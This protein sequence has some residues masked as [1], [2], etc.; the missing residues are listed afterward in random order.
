MAKFD[1]KIAKK[2]AKIANIQSLVT[3]MIC[4][5]TQL[6]WMATDTYNRHMSI[7]ISRFQDI[8]ELLRYEINQKTARKNDFGPQG[9]RKLGIFRKIK[10]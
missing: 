1:A 10:E 6:V 2:Q 4:I 9:P 8:N 7:I 3:Q 5:Y